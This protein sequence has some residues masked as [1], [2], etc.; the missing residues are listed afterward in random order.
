M[1]RNETPQ[2]NPHDCV[3]KV[4]R[5]KRRKRKHHCE[6][7]PTIINDSKLES[8]VKRIEKRENRNL[9]VKSMVYVVFVPNK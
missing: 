7:V 9:P 2:K 6:I 3:T 4:S 5:K 8:K 1:K